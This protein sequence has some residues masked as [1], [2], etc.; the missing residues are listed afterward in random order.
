MK[1]LLWLVA[2]GTMAAGCAAN[3]QNT[4][5]AAPLASEYAKYQIVDQEF[6][7]LTVPNDSYEKVTPYE[8]QV[9]GASYIQSTTS[10][11]K[12]AK[13]PARQMASQKVVVDGQ[14]HVLSGNTQAPITD[15]EALPDE[16]AAF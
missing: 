7:N 1:K 14:G 6:D 9:N 5:Q 10:K 8:D 2:V 11:K 13:K 12:G 16:R 3:K 4:E 15:E